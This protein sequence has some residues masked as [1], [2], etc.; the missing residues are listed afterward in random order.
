[1]ALN[2][3]QFFKATAA[4][5]GAA[6]TRQVE[7]QS[8]MSTSGGSPD[9]AKVRADFPWI[10]RQ[11]W[12]SGADYHPIGVHSIKAVENYTAYRAKGPGDGRQ[13]FT[14]RQQTESKELFAKLINAKP[15]EIAFVNS[16]TDAENLVV[17]GMDLPRKGGNV[18]ID[19]LHYQASKYLYRMLQRENKIEL[20]V[21][22][23]RNWTIDVNDIDKAVNRETRLVSLALVSNINGYLHKVKA[24]SDI[25]HSRGAIVYADI[26]QGVGHVPIDVQ[27]MGID[28]AGAGAYK[29]LMGDF[30]FGFL[31]VKEAL[32][33][34]V[35]QRSR[36]GV[37]Q[38]SAAAQSDA[39]FE[40][41]PGAAMFE[42]GSFAYSAGVCTH[43]ALKYIDALGIPNIR[44]HVKPLTDRLHREMPR[45]GFPAITPVDNPTPIVS[46]LTPKPE[47]TRAKMDKAFGETVIA[48][49]TWEFTD[50]NNRP[51]IQR[52]I[53]ISPSVYNNQ[54]DL[55]KLFRALA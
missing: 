43:A 11:V 4:V 16:T 45:L 7:A 34:N 48:F 40:L 15:S 6:S 18:V 52:G 14:G 20:K 10:Q 22:P 54:E 41:R 55:D 19:D 51:T 37:R 30:G 17:S 13:S 35:V 31:Y 27:A 46:F 36:W 49:R 8:S 47:E 32:Q 9:F 28:C 3:R 5:I 39:Q 38:Y 42:A 25:A 23:H 53:R 24:I 2:R 12:L 44:A 26:I 29:W 21:I 1:M 50:A 33:G